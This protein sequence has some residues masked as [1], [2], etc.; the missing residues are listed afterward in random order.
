MGK[1]QK[2]PQFQRWAQM[3]FAVIGQLLANPPAPGE[4]QVR[5]RELSQRNWQHPVTF[6][7]VFF[8]FSTIE[9]WY[10]RA[11][12][13]QEP[14]QVLARTRR[15]DL[16][17]SRSLDDATIAILQASYRDN[18][19]WSYL[20]HYDNLIAEQL[21]GKPGKAPSYATVWRYMRQ[22]G[23]IP[24]RHPADRHDTPGA[25]AT[26]LR[27][28]QREVRQFEHTHTHTLWHIDAHHGSIALS[29]Q[30]QMQRP[31]LIATI[32]DHSRYI[33]HAQWFWREEAASAAHT[34]M[35]SIAKRG[36]PRMLMSDNGGPFVAAEI[37]HGL[38]RLGVLHETTMCYAPNQ[39]GKMENFWAQV[40]GRLMAMLRHQR[41]LDLYRLNEITLAWIEH[42]YHRRHHSSL[43]TTPLDRYQNSPHVGRPA[44][45]STILTHAFTRRE[46]RRQRRSDGSISLGGIRFE[47]PSAYRHLTTIIIRYASWDMDHV[48]LAHPDTDSILDRLRPVDLQANASG[49]RALVTPPSMR[50]TLAAPAVPAGLPPLLRAALEAARAT[51]LPPAF[52]PVDDPHYS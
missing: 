10:Y 31:A 45:E 24:R 36:L 41:D 20:L 32:D 5:L 11:R 19:S 4:I 21:T 35:Q 43:G 14:T 3:R 39:N 17:R 44:P 29:H 16:G 6:L 38:H 9:R 23:Q 22:H 48:F 47:I 52:I 18:A 30:G 42:D 8:S 7:P 28:E 40:E 13:H 15:R 34:L 12:S 1:S 46:I 33:G 49:A 37:A 27:F 2:L 25:Q 50:P 51:G 26:R